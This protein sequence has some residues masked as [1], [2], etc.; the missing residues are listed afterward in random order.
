[1]RN[2]EGS[3][4]L[5]FPRRGLPL[6]SAQQT[7]APP[8][9]PPYSHQRLDLSPNNSNSTSRYKALLGKIVDQARE[10][11]ICQRF[12]RTRDAPVEI[13]R[14]AWTE[15]CMGRWAIT[16][17]EQHAVLR[18]VPACA[19]MCCSVLPSPPLTTS[20]NEAAILFS[21][22]CGS[23]CFAGLGMSVI[24]FEMTLPLLAER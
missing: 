14:R 13:N 21:T 9:A 1:M 8:R 2:P 18:A 16:G 17:M 11:N 3:T 19:Y 7:E 4:A 15:G 23:G 12:V 10:A 6:R 22:L 20:A 5:L 24:P